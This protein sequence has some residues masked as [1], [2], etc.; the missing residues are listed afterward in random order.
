MVTFEA[1]L[2]EIFKIDPLEEAAAMEYIQAYHLAYLCQEKE[3]EKEKSL[4]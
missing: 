4:F 2:E 3:K 1:L